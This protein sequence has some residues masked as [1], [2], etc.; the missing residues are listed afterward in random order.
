MKA[1]SAA[2]LTPARRCSSASNRP[3]ISRS[4]PTA[5]K[6]SSPAASTPAAAGNGAR[7]QM[8]ASVL[9][10]LKMMS[11]VLSQLA[12]I[13]QQVAPIAKSMREA[14]IGLEETAFDLSRYLDRL[15]LDPAELAEVDE[16]LNI[17]NR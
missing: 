8:D 4:P 15:E 10:R 11:A 13:D 9:E 16:R 3:A 17:L 6:S 7:S 2:S 5:A 12:M 14:T 1:E